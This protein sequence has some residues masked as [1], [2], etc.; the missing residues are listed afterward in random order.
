MGKQIMTILG[1]INLHY[2]A[3][4]YMSNY[5]RK[6][7]LPAPLMQSVT[8]LI[9]IPGVVSLIPTQSHT[10]VEIDHEIFSMFILLLPLIQ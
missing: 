2:W 8:S 1:Q 6:T 3:H 10:S 5:L 4:A 9:A 7:D